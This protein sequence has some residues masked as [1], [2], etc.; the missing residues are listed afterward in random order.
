MFLLRL[1]SFGGVRVSG[2]F[3][4]HFDASTAPDTRSALCL[5]RVDQML[6]SKQRV[7]HGTFFE[8]VTSLVD[9]DVLAKD[10]MSR[11]PVSGIVAGA[12]VGEGPGGDAPD[13]LS[14]VSFDDGVDAR[15]P[16]SSSSSSP[17]PP[18]Q[19][20]PLPP[21]TRLQRVTGHV[22]FKKT[23]NLM[24]AVGPM[25]MGRGEL[26]PPDVGSFVLGTME[27][28]VMD[29]R[30][31]SPPVRSNRQFKLTLQNWVSVSAGTARALAIMP[32]LQGLN[33]YGE[34]LTFFDEGELGDTMWVVLLFF[35][36]YDSGD[37]DQ[38]ELFARLTGRRDHA[39][40]TP[41][42]RARER[43]TTLAR[44]GFVFEVVAELER[45][46]NNDTFQFVQKLKTAQKE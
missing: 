22:Y 15:G 34:R 23:S 46:F 20:P 35:Q 12:G 19:R 27:N 3:F 39:D 44:P 11:M 40:V 6:L 14:V 26:G 43:G 16:S 9:T 41:D 21:P 25:R 8:G 17:S 38:M 5:M 10:V 13:C 28:R 31:L 32:L 7:V 29:P 30:G 24:L 1:A 36:A 18:M 37:D 33:L 42:C 45:V 4:H 2:S